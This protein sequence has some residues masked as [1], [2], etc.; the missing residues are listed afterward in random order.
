V[1][2][3]RVHERERFRRIGQLHR[4]DRTETAAHFLDPR[5]VGE[6]REVLVQ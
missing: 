2:A 4:R 3:Q 5:V 1:F 6:G